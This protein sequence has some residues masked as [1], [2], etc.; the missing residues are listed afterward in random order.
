MSA[1]DIQPDNAGSDIKNI[2]I[3]LFLLAL[4]LFIGTGGAGLPVDDAGA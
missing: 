4:A 2:G 3:A 1:S